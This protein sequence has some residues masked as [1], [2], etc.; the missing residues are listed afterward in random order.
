[1]R[2][3][4]TSY[5]TTPSGAYRCAAGAAGRHHAGGAAVAGRVQD[6]RAGGRNLAIGAA[7]ARLAHAHA[8]LAHALRGAPVHMV[9]KCT[10]ACTAAENGLHVEK[11][12]A[13]LPSLRTAYAALLVEIYVF[14]IRI[15]LY[16][17]SK[18]SGWRQRRARASWALGR[19]CPAQLVCEQ[20]SQGS[21]LHCS[22]SAGMR[23]GQWP[24]GMAPLMAS[25]HTTVRL[26][27]PTP[28]GAE[29]GPQGPTWHSTAAL[30]ACHA[31][32]C[33]PIC[34][35]RQSLPSTNDDIARAGRGTDKAPMIM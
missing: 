12:R 24:A 8:A 35:R 30:L 11:N 25:R 13:P 23:A 3:T 4:A 14:F 10:V 18:R 21:T 15:T 33:G 31:F 34:V 17:Q 6:A 19:A 1:V 7:E 20:K 27:T 9:S 2:R 28:H 29:H 22:S 32:M 26:R 16:Q 5:T